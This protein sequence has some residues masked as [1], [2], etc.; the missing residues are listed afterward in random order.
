MPTNFHSTALQ[1]TIAQ[2]DEQHEQMRKEEAIAV[3]SLGRIN[4][5]MLA[6][7]YPDAGMLEEVLEFAAG[8][9]SS[10]WKK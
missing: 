3:A 9:S 4:R 6:E 2:L 7:L 8:E 10:V 1:R 5:E